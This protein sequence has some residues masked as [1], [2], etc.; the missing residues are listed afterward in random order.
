MALFDLLA[1]VLSSID[2]F[3]EPF[4]NSFIRISFWALVSAL[5]TTIV[6]KKLSNPKNISHLKTKLKAMQAEL[7]QHDGEFSELKTLAIDTIKLSIKRM[8]LSFLPAMLASI[9]IVF[10]LT[11]LSNKYELAHPKDNEI[12]PIKITWENLKENNQISIIQNN[13]LLN[14][15][16]I[17]SF[18]WQEKNT[19]LVNLSDGQ[20]IITIPF[21]I[22]SIVHKKQWWNTLIGNP[23]GYLDEKSQV[24]SVEFS[25]KHQEIIYFG[26]EWVRGWLFI[27]FFMTLGFSIIFLFLF[28]IKF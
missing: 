21:P 18:S 4:T 25:F 7:N 20:D 22:S 23:A 2:K 14:S 5:I 6:F 26:P 11:Y 27:F 28:K 10:V 15:G 8:G 1:P 19:R 17:T 12:V 13:K 3:I 24:S 16:N 9:P